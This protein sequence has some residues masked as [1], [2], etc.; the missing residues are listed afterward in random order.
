[1]MYAIYGIN[2][3]AK[4]FVYMFPDINVVFYIDDKYDKTE[5]DNKKVYRLSDVDM[6]DKKALGFD[7]II[8]CDFLPER[9]EK[10]NSL[11]DLGLTYGKDFLY[12]EDFFG[13]LDGEG[14]QINPQNKPVIIWGT[15]KNASFFSKRFI[16]FRPEFYVDSNKGGTMFFEKQVK[17]PE[18]VENLESYFVII[19]VFKDKEIV[20]YLKEKGLKYGND[21]VNSEDIINTPS[22]MLRVT[23]FDKNTYSLNCH[24]PLNHIEFLTEGELYCCCS[25]FMISMGNV[26]DGGVEAVWNSNKHKILCLSA[27]NRTYSFCNSSMCPLLFGKKEKKQDDD[28]DEVYPVM[29]PSPEVA[30]IGF[31]YTCN[32]KCETCRKEVKVAKHA[33]KE[34]MLSFADYTINEILPDTKFFI[35]A[36]D[37][38]VFVSE[39]Y[40]RIYQSANM[41]HIDYIRILSNGTLF[42]ERNWEEFRKNKNGKILLT[43]SADAATK[44]TYEAIRRNGN[45][46]ILKANMAFAGELRRKGELSYLRMNFVVQRRNYKEMIDFVKWGLE[47]GADEVFFTKILNWGTFSADQFKE[48]SM[49]EED[50]ITA[51]PELKKIIEDPIMKNKI[52][53]LG[54]IQYAH[55]TSDDVDVENYYI[56]EM[57]RKVEGLF[58]GAI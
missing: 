7:K 54:T 30:A 27:V 43:A 28:L 21:Y 11:V 56:W 8:V 4:D 10:S 39:A 12:E 41:N 49:M 46:D 37:G 25:T 2:R 18:D 6:A 5:F 58:H 42:N 1:M 23:I 22:E 29:H 44:E 52:V 31:D 50:G 16:K 20:Q 40:K 17:F 57:E 45:F 15:G 51:K 47:I 38:E 32:L 9:R 34:K 3:V 14:R 13:L 55:T 53:D 35:L 19:A 26:R 36:G 48:I 24:T 33:D